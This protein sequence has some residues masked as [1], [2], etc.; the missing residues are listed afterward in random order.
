MNIKLHLD[1]AESAPVVRLAEALQVAP[2][3]VLYAALDRLMIGLQECRSPSCRSGRP[4][5]AC[6]SGRTPPAPCTP[7][8]ACRPAG[9]RRANIPFDAGRANH[10]GI[11][12]APVILAPRCRDHVVD[13]GSASFILSQGFGRQVLA[14]VG[15]PQAG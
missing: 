2:E 4:R 9:R 5:P 10:G 3:D 7:T 15:R 11:A 12:V 6:P 1:E 13:R 8:K 14:L